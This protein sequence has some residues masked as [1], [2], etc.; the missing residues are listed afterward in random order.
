M[1]LMY[2]EHEHLRTHNL[3]HGYANDLGYD[4]KSPY[5]GIITPRGDVIISTGLHLL[6][7][8]FVGGLIKTRSSMILLNVMADGVI[9]PDYTGELRIKLY[10]HDNNNPFYFQANDKIAQLVLVFQPMV[11]MKW[12][13]DSHN[14]DVQLARWFN[15]PNFKEIPYDEFLTHETSRSRKANGFG[16][17]GA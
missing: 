9:D 12:L 4:I 8:N 1:L 5:G 13:S 2:N 15:N 7:P 16:S 14:R 17:T 3:S 10:N 6:L 11:F